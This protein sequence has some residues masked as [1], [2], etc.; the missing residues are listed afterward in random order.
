MEHFSTNRMRQNVLYIIESGG[1]NMPR[2]PTQTARIKTHVK[3]INDIIEAGISH[4]GLD[5][6]CTLSKGRMLVDKE[7]LHTVTQVN[8]KLRRDFPIQ[9]DTQVKVVLDRRR[10]DRGDR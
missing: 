2:A 6:R 7:N 5:P 9:G 1:P 3:E 8:H 10:G 4:T